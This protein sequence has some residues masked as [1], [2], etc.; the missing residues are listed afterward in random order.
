VYSLELKGDD[1]NGN[2]NAGS[3]KKNLVDIKIVEKGTF[4]I[5]NGATKDNVLLKKR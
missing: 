4:S 3:A 5:T 2:S 1:D